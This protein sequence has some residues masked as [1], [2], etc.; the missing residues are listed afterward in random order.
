MN[1]KV[2]CDCCVVGGG[3][4]GIVL[5]LL[6]ARAGVRVT[7]L[8][9]HGDFLRDFRGDTIHPSTLEVMHQLGIL[10]R[11]LKVPHRRVEQLGLV[12]GDCEFPIAD[13]RHLP[14]QCRFVAFMPQ[15][16]FLNFIAQESARYPTY[17]LRM[18]TEAKELIQESGRTVGV[19]ASGPDGPIE[20]RAS[21][22]VGA[23][24]RQSLLR[25]QAGL[26]VQSLG[27]PMD[28]LWFR[29][30]RLPDDPPQPLGRFQGGRILIMIDRGE[31]WQVAYVIAKGTLEEFR[32][33]GLDAFREVIAG[34]V[35]FAR[36]RLSEIRGLDELKLL[37]VRIDRLREWYRPGLL[38]LGDAAHA[39]SPV[40]GVG[41][42][43]AIQDAVAAANE[44]ARPLREGRLTTNHLRRVQ[45]RRS[46]PTRI[47]QRLQMAMQDS[48]IYP[49]LT[50]KAKM[51]NPP[52]VFHVLRR[53]PVLRRIPATL[54]G[55]GIRM[56]R[57]RTVDATVGGGRE[58]ANGQGNGAAS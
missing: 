43:L 54:M 33:E 24:G 12:V 47:T 26:Q 36:A 17:S 46:F 18:R 6:L 2:T 11:F 3:P 31:H 58:G 10:E 39:M 57:V 16:D 13:F 8:E 40:G 42:N 56:E 51:V 44:L 53:F 49:A 7:V 23:D 20:V 48:M 38:F 34:L 21:L 45:E 1:E 19:R 15:W 29:L 14:T 28:A 50:G 37:S 41:V 32:R 30:P 5:G 35:P 25:D 55:M 4:A 52:P 27:A 22:V 9:K